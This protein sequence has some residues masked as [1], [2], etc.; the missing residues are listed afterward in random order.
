MLILNFLIIFQSNGRKLIE[1][2]AKGDLS[3][4]QSDF[5]VRAPLVGGVN[6]E[7]IVGR[8]AGV[9]HR[10]AAS[11][12]ERGG[13]KCHSPDSAG[14]IKAAASVFAWLRRSDHWKDMNFSSH[15]RRARSIDHISKFVFP[16][17]FGVFS[18]SFFIWFAWYSPAKLDTWA[19]DEYNPE[20]GTVN[21]MDKN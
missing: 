10:G 12:A 1:A 3:I 15:A 21:E 2:N 19:Y 16:F 14:R 17:L 8:G 5:E 4:N 7:P 6:D 11:G 20:N 9:N 13:S 18:V